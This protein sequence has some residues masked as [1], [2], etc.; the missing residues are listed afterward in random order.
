MS[1]AHPTCEHGF[2]SCH[3]CGTCLCGLASA[4][5]RHLTTEF[6]GCL[7]DHPDQE[8]VR[9]ALHRGELGFFEDA[10]LR[11]RGWEV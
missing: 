10:D 4:Y 2:D 9:N 7:D 1:N 8:Y 5:A 11:A 3:L 6:N